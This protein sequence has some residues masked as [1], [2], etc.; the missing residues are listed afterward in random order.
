MIRTMEQLVAKWREL[1]DSQGA[2]ACMTAIREDVVSGAGEAPAC[3]VRCLGDLWGED[4]LQLAA[5]VKRILDAPA[6]PVETNTVKALRAELLEKEG[7]YH[8]LTEQSQLL[9]TLEKRGDSLAAEKEALQMRLEDLL[10][11]SVA[12]SAQ[13][14]TVD[15]PEGMTPHLEARLEPIRQDLETARTRILTLKEDVWG[16]E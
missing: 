2:E 3:A 10:N 6:V 16:T 12:L 9:S 7:E 11:E 5:L 15:V 1:Y 8:S 13:L 14:G 4:S